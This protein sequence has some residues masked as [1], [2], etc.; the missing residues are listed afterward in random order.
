MRILQPTRVFATWTPRSKDVLENIDATSIVLRLF[1]AP[2][3]CKIRLLD[4]NQFVVLGSLCNAEV[5]V[6]GI[7]DTSG[8]VPSTSPK[9]WSEKRRVDGNGDDYHR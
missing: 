6:R 7:A 4:S 5:L 2:C 9:S 3:I 1:P 8:D